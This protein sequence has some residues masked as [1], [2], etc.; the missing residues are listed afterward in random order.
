MHAPT[1]SVSDTETASE[2]RATS[3][4]INLLRAVITWMDTRL[5]K[6][7]YVVHLVHMPRE[8]FCGRLLLL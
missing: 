6:A 7:M 5:L 4:D 1:A 8:A 3:A 2:S